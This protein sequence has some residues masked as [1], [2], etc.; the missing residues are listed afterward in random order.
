[1]KLAYFSPMPPEQS[2]IADYSAL[3]LPALRERIDVTVVRRGKKTAPRGTDVALYHVGNNPD[4]HA[5]IVDALRKR[6]GVVVLHDFALHHLV[7]GMT[8]GRRDGHAYLDLMEREQI[9][10]RLA[11]TVGNPTARSALDM[12]IWDALGQSLGYSVTELLGGYTDRMRVSHMLGFDE[13]AA[14][15]DEASPVSPLFTASPRGTPGVSERTTRAA[16]PPSWVA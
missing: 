2:G 14:M 11:R 8:V 9:H 10:S 5:W 3:L 4:A 7:A 13:P 12:A 16:R 1:M 6:P 15:V